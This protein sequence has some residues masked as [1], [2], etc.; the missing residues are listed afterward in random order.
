MPGLAWAPPFVT[1]ATYRNTFEVV[2]PKERTDNMLHLVT[3]LDLALNAR[4]SRSHLQENKQVIDS[5]HGL[6][7][8]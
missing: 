8:M 4:F 5:I 6:T 1:M 2:F 7:E 3:L